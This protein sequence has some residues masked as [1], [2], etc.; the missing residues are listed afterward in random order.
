M[1]ERRFTLKNPGEPRFHTILLVEALG[2]MASKGTIDTEEEDLY[3]VFHGRAE[4]MGWLTHPNSRYSVQALWAMHEAELTDDSLRVGFGQVGLDP[5]RVVPSVLPAVL[6]CLSDS[7][8]RFG[9][10]VSGFQVTT[11]EQIS[12]SDDECSWYLVGVLSWFQL[13]VRERV[14]AVVH[15][16]QGLLGDYDVSTL[17]ARLE[18]GNNGVF[19]FRLMDEVPVEAR[20]RLDSSFAVHSAF[21]LLRSK[22]GPARVDAGVVAKR[23]RMG[24]R[25]GHRR[26]LKLWGQIQAN[27]Q[28]ASHESWLDYP[29]RCPTHSG[30]LSLM[31]DADRVRPLPTLDVKGNLECLPWLDENPTSI[32]ID[33]LTGLGVQGMTG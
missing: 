24:T 13:D 22:P 28:F 27:T 14:R 29:I 9:A 6:Q 16:D 19:E 11:G 33:I 31:G 20:I 23:G 25:K 21:H 15:F 32:E 8:R 3:S 4:L 10:T 1:T 18:Q 12:L 30:L 5:T 26:L 7:V 17:A 2:S